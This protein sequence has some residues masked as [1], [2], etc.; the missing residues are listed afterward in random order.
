MAFADNLALIT[1][2]ISEMNEVLDRRKTQSMKG[3]KKKCQMNCYLFWI[4]SS[5][6]IL[7]EESDEEEETEINEEKNQCSKQ[8]FREFSRV[9]NDDP[10]TNNKVEGFHNLVNSTLGFNHPSIWKFIDGM[11]RLQNINKTKI[12]GFI[13]RGPWRS[14]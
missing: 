6:F 11:K 7:E 10:R 5:G 14:S 12:A 1:Y 13:A 3:Q 2:T 4:I 8:I 9:N